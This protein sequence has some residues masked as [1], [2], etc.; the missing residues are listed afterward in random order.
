MIG[1]SFC[2]DF[3]LLMCYDLITNF[4]DCEKINMKKAISLFICIILIFVSFSSAYIIESNA[5]QTK[6]DDVINTVI[7]N[8][9]V[10][11]G[12]SLV[13]GISRCFFIDFDFDGKLEFVAFYDLIAS[14]NLYRIYDVDTINNCLTELYYFCDKDT[15]DIKLLYNKFDCSMFYTVT[16]N[17]DRYFQ[18]AKY[19]VSAEYI[20]KSQNK[21]LQIS[22]LF[23]S[24]IYLD[25]PRWYFRGEE[26]SEEEYILEKNDFEKNILTCELEYTEVSINKSDSV[27]KK[28]SKLEQSY[29][30]FYC[31]SRNGLRIYS[32]YSN[33]TVQ[34]GRHIKIGAGVFENNHQMTD[35]SKVTLSIYDPSI[36]KI[37]YT[38]IHD[39]CRFYTLKANKAGMTYV[40]F[41]DSKTGYTKRVPVTVFDNYQT[42][43][44]I[45]SVPTINIEKY[46]TNF[47]NH[48]GL[49]VDNY[50]YIMNEDSSAN[51]SF[52]VYNTNY[53]YGAVEVY[54]SSGN[55]KDA[56]II[57]K[58]TNNTGSIKEV[59]WD[60]A[61]CIVN[62]F[63]EWDWITYRQE[64]GY[65]KK[66][67]VDINIPKNGYI[68]IT[69]D[70]ASSFLVNLINGTDIL[71]SIKEISGDIKGFS[72]NSKNFSEKITYEMINSTV[73]SSLVKDESTFIK[74]LNKNILKD[75][76][77]SNKSLGDFANT[78]VNNL[79]ELNLDKIILDTAADFGWNI[80]QDV[81]VFF[82]GP[83]GK[84]IDGVF[85]GGKICNVINQNIDY[86]YAMLSGSICIQNQGGGYRSASQVEVRTNSDFNSD[87]AL[88]VFKVT[89]E[90]E[91]LDLL[92][93]IDSDIYERLESEYSHIYNISMIKNGVETQLEG[94][95][96]V[97]IP[98]PEN[99]ELLTHTDM[100]NVY[101]IEEDGTITQM[102]AS[103]K[104]GCIIFKTD[105]FSL[106]A[107]IGPES[108]NLG[109]IDG[110][111]KVTILDATS[112][113]RHLAE[114]AMIT[115]DRL[116]YA[117]TD[118]DGKTTIL[119]ATQIQR[120]LAEIITEF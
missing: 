115:D 5:T 103:I 44:T 80:A 118:K 76:F 21:Q 70:P 79:H 62:D 101:R 71:M 69:I 40:S 51:V 116:V 7:N 20:I 24:G 77:G 104:G 13:D 29:D 1:L 4:E 61:C 93:I 106:Y 95:V 98:I 84:V 19:K 87:V 35:V 107:I 49:Y 31:E 110:D 67:S 72:K 18:L 66:T 117:D 39:N 60:N 73:Y 57:D 33:L 113:Q 97:S 27:D 54:D 15:L 83:I 75:T 56:V 41:S 114:I 108:F 34:K 50:E 22:E 82:S 17:I 89:V 32:D 47:Y 8:Y 102:E 2:V 65:S 94:P 96:E 85:V 86:N 81:F 9:D 59:F 91:Y 14:G 30:G 64:T 63:I 11:K 6:K 48:A 119:D 38:G 90:N 92:E 52:D 45:S 105:H 36:L 42:S 25:I 43:Y 12:S 100:I 112:I 10:W 55:L 68:K 46:D 109:D 111:G 37:V 3:I 28:T 58:M 120:L 23:A 99:L 16:Q 74:D 26:I 88:K 53:I 78:F